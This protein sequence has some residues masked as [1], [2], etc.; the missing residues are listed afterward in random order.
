MNE[1]LIHDYWLETVQNTY[2]AFEVDIQAVVGGVVI[3]REQEPW[4]FG[5][6]EQHTVDVLDI[7]GWVY[8]KINKG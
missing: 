3:F 2:P 4:I 7:L 8:S 1:K 5:S 6:F